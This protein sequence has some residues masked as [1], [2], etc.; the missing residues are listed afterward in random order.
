ML[1][2]VPAVGLLAFGPRGIDTPPDNRIVVEYWE[3]WTGEEGAALRVLVNDF[4]KTRGK[5]KGV[6]VN[7]LTTSGT[8][9]KTLV[10]TAAGVPPDIAGLENTQL[11]QFA[12]LDALEKLDD[13]AAAKQI[14]GDRYKKVYWDTCR[15]HGNLYG[16]PSTPYNYAFFYDQRAFDKNADKL[17]AAGMSPDRSPRTITELDTYAKCLDEIGG[18]GR[19][20]VAGYLPLEPGWILQ[21]TCFWFG[22]SWWDDEHERFDLL[23]PAVVDSFRWIQSYSKRLGLQAVQSFRSGVGNFDSPQNAFMNGQVVMEQQ[24]TFMASFIHNRNSTMDGHWVAAKFPGITEELSNATYCNTNVF[25]IPR[26]ARHKKEA[27][28]FIAWMQEQGPMEK[29]CGLHCKLSALKTVSPEFLNHNTNP[30]IKVFDDLAASPYA[31]CAPQC[32]ILPEVS[33]EF[34]AF[35]QRLANLEVTPEQGLAEMQERLQ[36]SLDHFK[37]IQAI[38]VANRQPAAMN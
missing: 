22:G 15:Y 17:R 3:E 23:N 7:L 38:R 12:E 8:L 5:E 28:E 24:G 30:Y 36:R 32:P 25:T 9:Q 14:T 13:L 11:A 31:R 16:L 2:A 19:I 35:T 34:L 26:G 33:E 29:L 4:N 1:L 27:F 37:K 6:F 20:R 10:S 18:D 21:Y